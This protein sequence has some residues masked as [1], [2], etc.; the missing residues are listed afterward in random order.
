[1]PSKSNSSVGGGDVAPANSAGAAAGVGAGAAGFAAAPCAPPHGPFFTLAPR[2][3]AGGAATGAGGAGA[4]GATGV[5]DGSLYHRR[6]SYAATTKALY[7]SRG[8]PGR[9]R[10]GSSRAHRASHVLRTASFEPPERGRS[11]STSAAEKLL[12][13]ISCRN[14]GEGVLG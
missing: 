8:S 14:V 2:A 13:L 10:A 12:W 6:C 4:G 5:A 9:G 11:A 1:M 3:S 7:F